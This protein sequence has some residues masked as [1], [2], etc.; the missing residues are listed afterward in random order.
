MSIQ[1][2]SEPSRAH[3]L[4]FGA[5]IHYTA[6]SSTIAR[7]AALE[8]CSTPPSNESFEH[9]VGLER[10]NEHLMLEHCCLDGR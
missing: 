2:K 4:E 10:P 8:S 9:L 7:S 3:R 1:S 5:C 6:F